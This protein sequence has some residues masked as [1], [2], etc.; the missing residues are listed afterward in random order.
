MASPIL[1]QVRDCPCIL[2]NVMTESFVA[3]HVMQALDMNVLCTREK[4]DGE[5][6]SCER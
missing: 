3:K 5:Y 1:I 4:L 6:V 2:A